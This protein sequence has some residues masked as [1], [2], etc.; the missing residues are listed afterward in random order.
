MP[1]RRGKT[2]FPPLLD[3]M[4]FVTQPSMQLAFVATR[5]HCWFPFNLSSTRTPRSFCR[6]AATVHPQ[7]VLRH[8]VIFWQMQGFA[9][10]SVELWEASVFLQSDVPLNGSSPVPQHISHSPLHLVLSTNLMIRYIPWPRWLMK[11]LNGISLST[12]EEYQPSPP[13][14]KVSCMVGRVLISVFHKVL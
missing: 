1:S 5:L 3:S 12:Y 11:M 7:P 14:F 6:A 13:H 2:H 4:L 10:V 9:L 8:R